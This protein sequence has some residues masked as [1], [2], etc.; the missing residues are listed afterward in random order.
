MSVERVICT[1]SMLKI[2]I[3]NKLDE[4]A[5]VPGNHAE[6]MTGLVSVDIANAIVDNTTI[7]LQALKAPI[8]PQIDLLNRKLA[9]A[10]AC[11]EMQTEMVQ[12]YANLYGPLPRRA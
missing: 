1:P 7:P 8:D 6:T 5:K 3:R 12:Q 10:Q 2:I 4:W 11:L 9:A